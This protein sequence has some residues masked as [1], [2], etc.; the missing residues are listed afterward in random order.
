MTHVRFRK[1]LT[2]VVSTLLLFAVWQAA[3]WTFRIPT[4]ILPTPLE[5]MAA[6][7]E[8]WSGIWPNAVH[9]LLTTPVEVVAQLLPGSQIPWGQ[10]LAVPG[11]QPGGCPRYE[12]HR[13]PKDQ[14]W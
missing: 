14:R 12:L 1:Q 10:F 4:F 13:T 11:A 2:P 7:M 9:T 3:C 6:L 8:N 5:S